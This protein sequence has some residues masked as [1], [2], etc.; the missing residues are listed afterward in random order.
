MRLALVRMHYQAGGGAERSLELLARGLLQRGHQ[1]LVV[2]CSWQGT[3]PRGLELALV[4]PGRGGGG[5]RALGFAAAARRRVRQWR[6]DTWLSL[7]KVPGCPLYRAGDGCHA[8]WLQRRSRLAPGWKRL[9]LR[10]D[11]KHRRWLELER[12]TLRAPE[13]RLVLANSRLVAGELERFYGLEGDKVRL[14]RNGVEEEALEAARPPEVREQVRRE[15]GLGRDQPVLLFLGSGFERKGLAFAI[16]A[17]A[18][19]PGVVLLVA[20]RDRPRAYRHQA[21]RTGLEAR[22]RFLGLRRDAPRLISACDALVLPTI[23]DPCANACLE[24]LYLGRPVVTT[25]A[26]GA[27]E[28]VQPG[29]S[30]QVVDDPSHIQELAAACRQVLALDQPFPNPVPSRR[31]WLDET[32]ALLEEAAA[33]SPGRVS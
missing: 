11:P 32:L 33:G 30:G 22:V 25:R 14:L 2:T 7:D 27:A 6:P 26:D 10:L 28:L 1:V 13:L 15:L 20:G 8:A 12:R 5:G 31:S 18:H 9:A 17:L 19:L 16:A 21:R 29:L 4:D 24:A 23:Y 3:P